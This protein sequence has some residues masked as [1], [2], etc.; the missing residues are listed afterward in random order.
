MSGAGRV[1]FIGHGAER[2]GPPVFLLH[3]Q[4][5]LARQGVPFETV[6]ARGGDLLAEYR[7]LGAVRVLDRR[8][9]VPRI[10]QAGLGRSDRVGA[11]DQVRA[12]RH[13]ATVAGVGGA[14]VV[15][16][17]T[18]SPGG[19]AALR[20]LRPSGRVVSHIHELEVGLQ[21]G[22]DDA[23]RRLLL[24]ATDRFIAA[25]QAVADNLTARHGVEPHRVAVH[26]EFIDTTARPD[27]MRAGALRAA[28]GIDP[29]SFV[30][31][32][33]GMTDWRKAPDL[34]V[35][36]GWELGRHPLARPVHL[37]WVGGSPGGPP[38][39]QEDLR[40]LGLERRVHFTGATDRPLDA[41]SLCDLFVLPS[42]EDA[43][44]LACLEA[45]SLGVPIVC[46]DSGGMPELVGP[47]GGGVVVPYPDIAR[48]AEVVAELAADDAR[49]SAMG[50]A[51]QAAV[52]AHHDVEVA[53]PGLL[54]ELLPEAV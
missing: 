14:E 12:W 7:Q 26:H 17:N 16:L 34:F 51:V 39:L 22:L 50:E 6:L 31:G 49:R 28:L 1:L 4:R 44:P 5:W 45:G 35:R 11:A 37:V 10:V 47:S 25:S 19:L 3:F 21:H 2:S 38:E 46:F 48:M 18:A 20:S 42:R 8:W 9:T 23:D 24:S 53:A 13:R 33:S 52:S 32:A 27:P 41:F 40:R 15:Y 29:T 30:V 36:L 54:A 43:F